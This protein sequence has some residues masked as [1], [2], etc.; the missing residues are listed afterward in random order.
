MLKTDAYGPILPYLMYQSLVPTPLEYQEYKLQQRYL[1][2]FASA[3]SAVNHSL[4][5]SRAITLGYQAIRL[6]RLQ[7]LPRL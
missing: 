1:S 7:R 3:A 6:A 4:A 2:T 5:V